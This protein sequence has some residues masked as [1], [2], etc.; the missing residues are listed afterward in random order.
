MQD[1]I[2]E[3]DSQKSR[4]GGFS[5]HPKQEKLKLLLV[6]H[7]AQKRF[8]KDDAEAHGNDQIPSGDSRVMVFVSFRQGVDEVVDLLSR[9]KPLIRPIP[10][11][12]QGMDKNG[13]KGY[14]QREQLDVSP[15]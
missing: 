8:D 3:L 11:I 12:G 10:F 2:K 7:F 14:G 4:S 13:K 1:V 15:K 9:E 6:E 5:M